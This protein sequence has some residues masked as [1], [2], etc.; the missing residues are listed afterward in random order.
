M[1]KIFIIFILLFSLILFSNGDE[2]IQTYYEYSKIASIISK[3]IKD[4]VKGDVVI[5]IYEKIF[6]N[7]Y[8]SDYKNEYDGFNT[9][10][11]AKNSIPFIKYSSTAFAFFAVSVFDLFKNLNSNVLYFSMMMPL[12][13][14]FFFLTNPISDDVKN[15]Y[16]DSRLLKSLIEE[17]L[18]N[19]KNI[20][21]NSSISEKTNYIVDIYIHNLSQITTLKN[22]GISYSKKRYLNYVITME[23]SNNFG[24]KVLQK[25]YSDSKIIEDKENLKILEFLFDLSLF[26]AGIIL[27][28]NK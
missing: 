1:K 15:K 11:I 14:D 18:I 12:A 28:Y 17:R 24:K 22:Y 16:I 26:G 23:I 7:K 5:R 10:N 27:M 13:A 6:P 20:N 3:D 8:L 9:L 4:T 25:S 21:L 2:N 19:D